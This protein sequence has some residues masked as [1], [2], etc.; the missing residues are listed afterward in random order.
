MTL[1]KVMAP[2][3]PFIA[4]KIYG[5]LGGKKES[6]HL[7]D[8]PEVQKVDKDILVEMDKVRKV[9]ELG[10]SLRAEKGIKVR[11]PLSKVVISE[12][13]EEGLL[14]VI[15]EELNVKEAIFDKKFSHEGNVKESNGLKVWLDTEISEDL[16]KEGAVREIVRTINQMRKDQKLT[17]SDKIVVFFDTRSKELAGL[18]I[19]NMDKLKQS[20]LAEKI[21]K[22]ATL[23]KEVEIDGEKIQ[24]SVEKI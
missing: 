13:I 7:E 21:E 2:V 24:L 18:V 20:V 10:L 4:E 8:W 17:V 5:C 23:S 19:E 22:R 6:V 14:K 12:K 16:K 1:S 11:Q 3:T 9:V 15:A